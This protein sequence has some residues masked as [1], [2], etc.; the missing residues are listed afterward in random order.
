MA[1]GRDD[2]F[3]AAIA[4]SLILSCHAT[5]DRIMTSPS[6]RYR[7]YLETLTPESMARLDEFVSSDVRFK[8][9]FTEVTGIDAMAQV[10]HHMF[11][12]L[13]PVAFKVHEL[14]VDGDVCLMTWRFDAELRGR[15]WSFE[16]ASSIR[17]DADGRVIEHIDHWD[18]ASAFY[19]RLP[20]IGWMLARIRA[21][22]AIH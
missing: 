8:D 16:G 14:A 11:E 9:P 21:R 6:E 19:E 7:T 3:A 12:N 2:A 20:F 17:F 10:F 15:P 1:I 18:A 22:L 13:G 5:D 4:Q